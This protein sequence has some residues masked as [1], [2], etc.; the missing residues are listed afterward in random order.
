LRVHRIAS[1]ALRLPVRGYD[2]AAS[3][4]KYYRLL[5]LCG[6]KSIS[7][8]NWISLSV[9]CR[10]SGRFASAVLPMSLSRVIAT[11]ATTGRCRYFERYLS[12]CCAQRVS[13]AS[14]GVLPRPIVL[15][16]P[17]VVVACARLTHCLAAMLVWLSF[18]LLAKLLFAHCSSPSHIPFWFCSTGVQV[19]IQLSRA[20]TGGE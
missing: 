7:L 2:V 19:T 12:R 8:N 14:P 6:R 16:S 9:L 5:L 10:R 13:T 3:T 15:C 1:V 11:L 4:C 17:I 18:A 20:S